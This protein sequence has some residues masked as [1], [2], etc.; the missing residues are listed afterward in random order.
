MTILAPITHFINWLKGLFTPKKQV[1]VL[2]EEVKPEH[3]S[4][5]LRFRKNCPAC[6]EIV[7]G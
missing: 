1:V 6:K 7:Y 3:C 5:H 4:G 2:Q